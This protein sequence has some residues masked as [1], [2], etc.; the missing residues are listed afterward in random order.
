MTWFKWRGLA[1]DDGWVA[2]GRGFEGRHS[3]RDEE[4]ECA[5]RLG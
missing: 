1:D 5:G 2:R 3:G 4:L